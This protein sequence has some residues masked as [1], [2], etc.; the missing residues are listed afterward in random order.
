MIHYHGT[1]LSGDKLTTIRALAGKHA[2][3]SFADAG[4]MEVVAEVCQSFCID[5]GAY[6]VWKKGGVLDIPA[7]AQFVEGWIRHPGF[8]FYCIPDVIDGGEQANRE[9][10]AEWRGIIAH[11]MRFHGAPVWHLDESLELLAYYSR[12]YYRVAIGS[13]GAFS[14]V[15]SPVWW[16]RIAEAMGVV[17]DSGRPR[18]KLHFLRCLDPTVFAHVPAAS[19]DSTN[20][21]RNIGIDSAWTGTY[22]PASREARA[23]VLMERI[24]RHAS[25]AEWHGDSAGVQQNLALFG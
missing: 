15:G 25:A 3:V 8:D 5:S 12:A 10:V 18:V 20:V 24:E 21:A 17:C 16:G 2:M 19:C 13:A 1:R 6:T 7:Y 4:D 14:L 11:D 9:L 23:M 22:S